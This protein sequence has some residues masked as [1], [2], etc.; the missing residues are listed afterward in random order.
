VVGLHRRQTLDR[1]IV[2]LVVDDGVVPF[3]TTATACRALT[4]AVVVKLSRVIFSPCWSP[5]PAW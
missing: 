2:D 3:G 1:Q 5:G 4:T